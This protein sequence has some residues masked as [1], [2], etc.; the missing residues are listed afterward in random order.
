M[1]MK[2]SSRSASN[3]A[4]LQRKADHLVDRYCERRESDEEN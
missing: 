4:A 2:I 3:C 1:A